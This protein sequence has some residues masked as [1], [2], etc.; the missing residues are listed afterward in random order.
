[1]NILRNFLVLGFSLFFAS[2]VLGREIIVVNGL[3]DTT[4]EATGKYHTNENE[5]YN[6]AHKNKRIEPGKCGEFYTTRKGMVQW[7]LSSL[8]ISSSQG[9]LHQCA[10][11]E[12]CKAS[13]NMVIFQGSNGQPV[14]FPIPSDDVECD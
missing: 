8:S 11:I 1:M 10:G 12:D 2:N 9:V 6:I 3:P 7:E 4:I 5:G 13:P 14:I